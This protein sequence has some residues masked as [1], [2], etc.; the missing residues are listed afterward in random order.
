MPVPH[1][2]G[3]PQMKLKLLVI[4]NPNNIILFMH[5]ADTLWKYMHYLRNMMT[6]TS[7]DSEVPTSLVDWHLYRPLSA[8]KWRYGM[9]IM[10]A[11]IQTNETWL[12]WYVAGIQ[13][14]RSLCHHQYLLDILIMNIHLLSN[15]WWLT[16]AD[17]YVQQPPPNILLQWLYRHD[18]TARSRLT[19]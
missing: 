9:Q 11:L 6:R 12:M 14:R 10:A 15:Q 7:V 1:Q 19:M 3:A 4:D 16:N 17:Y 2:V 18:K 5:I 8:L 13:T